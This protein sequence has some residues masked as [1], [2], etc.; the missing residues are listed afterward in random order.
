MSDV[1]QKPGSVVNEA[2]KYTMFCD[3]LCYGAK[4][5][6]RKCH[7]T[8]DSRYGLCVMPS[9]NE[10]KLYIFASLATEPGFCP[11]IFNRKEKQCS[12]L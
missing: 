8:H 3:L 9:T 1:G 12:L 6:N 2:K 11:D 7:C 4:T 10:Q 5:M